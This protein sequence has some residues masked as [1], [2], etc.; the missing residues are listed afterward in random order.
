MPNLLA[1]SIIEALNCKQTVA[2]FHMD[3]PA[4]VFALVS[5]LV[6]TSLQQNYALTESNLARNH[7]SIA[8]LLARNKA[9]KGEQRFKRTKLAQ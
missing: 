9:V 1:A 5:E 6:L 4:N 7:P 8:E 3:L 2:S